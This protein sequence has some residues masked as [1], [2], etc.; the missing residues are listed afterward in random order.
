MADHTKIK[1]T[2]NHKPLE[3][4]AGITVSEL[5]VQSGFPKSVAVFVNKQPLL[6]KSYAVHVLGEADQVTVF[7]PLGGG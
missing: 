1:I 5:L 7:R 6:M 4:E 2:L 3:V